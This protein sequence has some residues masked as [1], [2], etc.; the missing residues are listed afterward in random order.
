[1]A[2]SIFLLINGWLSLCCSCFFLIV[3]KS[4]SPFSSHSFSPNGTCTCL[5]FSKSEIISSNKNKTRKE[6]PW[7]AVLIP[8]N[9]KNLWEKKILQ[10]NFDLTN[11]FWWYLN[12]QIFCR[13]NKL[14]DNQ[15][16]EISWF[17]LFGFNWVSSTS[18]SSISLLIKSLE[19]KSCAWQLFHVSKLMVFLNG[20]TRNNIPLSRWRE[21]GPWLCQPA[22]CCCG[23]SCPPELWGQHSGR[24]ARSQ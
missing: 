5:S 9:W 17:K 15:W 6:V 19:T 11:I 20:W 10:W 14:W 13:C 3:L 12:R 23:S 16:L 18:L 1:M 8:L 4:S 7:D 22:V 2:I 21:H 24:R